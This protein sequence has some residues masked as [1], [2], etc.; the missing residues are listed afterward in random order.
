MEAER[1]Q[2]SCRRVVLLLEGDGHVAHQD[3]VGRTGEEMLL[4]RFEHE[5][6][7]RLETILDHT[8]LF[9]LPGPD[10]AG[11]R[12]KEKAFEMGVGVVPE[13]HAVLFDDEHLGL[14]RLRKVRRRPKGRQRTT[15]IIIPVCLPENSHVY[16]KCRKCGLILISKFDEFVNI[17]KKIFFCYTTSICPN[18]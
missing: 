1:L 3:H 13:S 8:F 18:A 10:H 2:M 4:T 5:H 9:V 15:S 11:P 16:L 17:E 6:H 14:H 12:H 7:R